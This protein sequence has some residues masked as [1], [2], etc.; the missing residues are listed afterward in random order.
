MSTL[1]LYRNENVQSEVSSASAPAS[2]GSVGSEY[3]LFVRGFDANS[4]QVPFT[5]PDAMNL[6]LTHEQG[7]T[8]TNFIYNSTLNAEGAVRVS[9]TPSRNGTFKLSS[10]L[11]AVGEQ[12]AGEPAT[13]EA[14][15]AWEPSAKRSL[16]IASASHT[17]SVSSFFQ[18]WVEVHDA[19]DNYVDAT[20]ISTDERLSFIASVRRYSD[21]EGRYLEAQPL[22]PPAVAP[23]PSELNRVMLNWQMVLNNTGLHKF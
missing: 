5:S 16:I 2:L 13:I 4:N 10:P 22:G 19:F 18:L 14:Q 9:F 23:N 21:E 7:V 15:S 20:L 12:A 8:V 11:L 1:R 17:A 3:S 6:K